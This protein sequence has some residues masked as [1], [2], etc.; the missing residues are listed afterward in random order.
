MDEDVSVSPVKISD[1]DCHFIYRGMKVN[2]ISGFLV[3]QQLPNFKKSNKTWEFTHY[4]LN[5]MVTESQVEF[6]SP[7]L[8]L[9]EANI[10][11]VAARARS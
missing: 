8:T 1:K 5:H 2:L 10:F 7:S 4:L 9:L 3:N 11:T 6:R